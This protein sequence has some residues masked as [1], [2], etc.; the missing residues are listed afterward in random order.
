M[1]TGSVTVSRSS[2]LG[3]EA[4]GLCLDL[5]DAERLALDPVRPTASTRN[6]ARSSMQ[7]LAQ[8]ELRDQHPSCS[9]RRTVA[10]VRGNGL[11]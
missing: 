3:Q 1:E 2:V 4:L 8:V 11:R 6:L 5:A 10:G 9:S 7:Q